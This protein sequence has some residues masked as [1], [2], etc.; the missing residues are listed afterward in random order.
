MR[1]DRLRPIIV[2]VL[3]M[4]AMAGNAAA[5]PFRLA[6]LP[7][8]Q[9]YSANPD[10]SSYAGQENPFETQVR[11]I[12]DNR[13]SLDIAFTIHLGDIVDDSTDNAQW[14]YAD[15]TMRVFDEALQPLDAA[16]VPYAVVRGNHDAYDDFSFLAWFGPQR[17]AGK[18]SYRGSDAS[19]LN[20]YHIFTVGER[21]FLVLLTDWRM[22]EA[23]RTWAQ[24]VLD[25][26]PRIPTILVSHQIITSSDGNH[27]APNS[28]AV[29]TTYGEWLWDNL[30]KDHDQIFMTLNGHHASSAWRVRH[31]SAG[32][33]VVQILADYQ[34]APFAGAGYLLEL[35]IDTDAGRITGSTYSP[36]IKAIRDSGQTAQVLGFFAPV[37]PTEITVPSAAFDISLAFDSRFCDTPVGCGLVQAPSATPVPFPLAAL[38]LLAPGLTLLAMGL[39]RR[40]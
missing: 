4:A 1:R 34:F 37:L 8:T 16:G 5:Q 9:F 22:D 26:H 14:V 7:D 19:G 21:P 35:L 11:W 33:E 38:L 25:A 28:Q 32:H 17:F 24:G 36:W 31:N 10:T 18:P 13:E 27:L 29:D 23:Q 3:L 2:C 20:S 15:Q 30:I 12:V 40:A 39:R 6:V